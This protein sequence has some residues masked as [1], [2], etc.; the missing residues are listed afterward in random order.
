MEDFSFLIILV[1]SSNLWGRWEVPSRSSFETSIS[2][3]LD[4]DFHVFLEQRCHVLEVHME[5]IHNFSP[6]QLIAF[7]LNCKP[8]PVQFRHNYVPVQSVCP[9]SSR[10]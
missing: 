5:K 10:L 9:A 6:N 7:G 8:V 4:F 2:E 3:H 1:R